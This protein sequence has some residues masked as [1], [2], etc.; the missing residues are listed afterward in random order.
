MKGVS[1]LGAGGHSRSLISCLD[2]L[3]ISVLNVYDEQS[4]KS[5]SIMG[6]KVSSFE[7]SSNI[8]NLILAIGD[9]NKRKFFLESYYTKLW[10]ENIIH[11]SAWLDKTSVLG[12]ANQVL[13]G[14]YVGPETK[15]GI[16][17]IVNTHAVVEHESVIGDHN[18]ISVSTKLLGRVRVGDRCFIGAGVV[19]KEGISIGDDIVIGA[20]SFVNEHLLVP[21]VYVGAPIRRIE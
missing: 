11:P 10:L 3:N 16:N 19:V 2:A 4:Q 5:E 7:H 8:E 15:I 6:I 9:N 14:A 13:C 18:H 21:G 1:I 17:N 20:N 12:N